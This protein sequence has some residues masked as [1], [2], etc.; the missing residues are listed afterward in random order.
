MNARL[1]DGELIPL[2][3]GQYRLRGVTPCAFGGYGVSAFDFER[4][5]DKSL[6]L[7]GGGLNNGDKGDSCIRLFA[8]IYGMYLVVD[9]LLMESGSH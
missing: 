1:S 8:V 6:V 5:G 2:S 3:G 9:G 4:D 7:S